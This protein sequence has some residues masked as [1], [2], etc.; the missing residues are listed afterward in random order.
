MFVVKLFDNKLQLSVVLFH[1]AI[2]CLHDWPSFKITL[3]QS[4]V[5]PRGKNGAEFPKLP[6]ISFTEE[7]A[8][9]RNLCFTLKNLQ[10]VTLKFCPFIAL[11]TIFKK[12]WNNCA[13]DRQK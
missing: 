2:V 9:S 11:S 4:S 5:G 3:N 10:Q 13:E 12:I 1:V 7:E 8:D 6:R